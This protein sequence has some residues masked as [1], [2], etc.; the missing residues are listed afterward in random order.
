MTRG[1]PGA[2][3]FARGQAV[4]AALVVTSAS[5]VNHIDWPWLCFE[6]LGGDAVRMLKAYLLTEKSIRRLATEL[7]L[8]P[9]ASQSRADRRERLHAP[10]SRLVAG[11][12]D[13]YRHVNRS[14]PRP[15]TICEF[16]GNWIRVEKLWTGDISA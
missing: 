13:R 5:R 2:F 10:R 15:D 12:P 6:V 1:V 7:K 4:V 8:K 11:T 16:C 14:M 9:G 3:S